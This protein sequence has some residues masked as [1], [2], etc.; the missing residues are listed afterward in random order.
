M[1]IYKLSSLYVSHYVFVCVVCTFHTCDI[2][3]SS[4]KQVANEKS[5]MTVKSICVT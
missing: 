2:P 5:T 4:D 1:N 3:P